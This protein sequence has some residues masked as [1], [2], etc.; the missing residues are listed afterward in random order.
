MAITDSIQK[1]TSKARD[2]AGVAAAVADFPGVPE[3]I[4]NSIQSLFGS[5]AGVGAGSNRRDLNNFLGAV[6]RLNGFSRPAYFYVEI[7]PPLMMREETENARTL[8]FLS[9]STSLPGVSLATSDVR[10]FGYGPIEKKPYAPIFV[11]S[12]FTFLVDGSGMI[13]K[14]FYK[15]MNGI[16]KFD[17][18][19]FGGYGQAGQTLIA[20]FEVNYKEQ[21]RTDILITTVDENNNDIINVRLFDAYPIFMGDVALGWADTDSV[22]RL[23]ITFT[24][25]NWKIENININQL[26]TKREEGILQKVIRA[27]TALQT[28][29]TIRKPNSVADVINVVNNSKIAIGGL[30]GIF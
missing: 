10:R 17:D 22:A 9:E 30:S 25:F 2:V 5:G 18:M 3:G 7:A 26:Q 4:R 16:V 12:T 13:Q 23:P 11:D 8:A 6:S 24:Y 14:F 21:Y 27:G 1:F 19:P 28:L 15:W 29:S 20:P